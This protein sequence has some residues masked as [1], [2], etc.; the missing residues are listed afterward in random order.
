MN[1]KYSIIVATIVAL[2]EAGHFNGDLN[3]KILSGQYEL[4]PSD[5]VLKKF[6][7][8]LTSETNLLEGEN[9][10]V[11]GVNDFDSGNKLG[12]NR[13]FI[14]SDIRIDYGNAPDAEVNVAKAIFG[15]VNSPET[16]EAKLRYKTN[17]GT[18]V[19]DRSVSAVTQGVSTDDRKSTDAMAPLHKPLVLVNESA[20]EVILK[21]PTGLSV[22][23]AGVGINRAIAI[24][25]DG[26]EI[27]GK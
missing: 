9:Q 27:I 7:N 1:N 15:G 24:R 25:L 4:R 11:A 22:P 8:G 12:A 13:A 21:Y 6:I 26:W 10:Q 5:I 3:Q 16:N 18:L 20:Q 23:A 19:Y 2:A 14:A 17:D